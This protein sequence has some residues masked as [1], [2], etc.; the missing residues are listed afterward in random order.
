[1]DVPGAVV[2][3]RS[4]FINPSGFAAFSAEYFTLNTGLDTT[5][6]VDCWERAT[7]RSQLCRD[8]ALLQAMLDFHFQ[9]ATIRHH[10]G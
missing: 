2:R 7:L 8:A 3:Q 5:L 4:G 9:S 6:L 1:M 10:Q